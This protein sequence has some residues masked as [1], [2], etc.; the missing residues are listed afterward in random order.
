M[1]Y[2][3]GVSHYETK[4]CRCAEQVYDMG[5]NRFHPPRFCN[6]DS[7]EILHYLFSFLHHS[8]EQNWIMLVVTEYRREKKKKKKQKEKYTQPK[9][10]T[11]VS[12]L[13]LSQNF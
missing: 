9:D 4:R 3:F 6:C 11:S 13:E 2:Y 5:F 1:L 12:N 10:S 7:P 8:L